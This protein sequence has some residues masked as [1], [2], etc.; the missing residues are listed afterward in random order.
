[1]HVESRA[2]SAYYFPPKTMMLAARR[3]SERA[4][5]E[6]YELFTSDATAVEF[7]KAREEV[8]GKP[9]TFAEKLEVRIVSK[10][11]RADDLADKYIEEDVIPRGVIQTPRILPSQA[12]CASID[13]KR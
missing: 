4:R 8:R 6:K 3:F 7:E 5:E 13:R 9:L 10:T 1:M 11:A 12:S 2:V